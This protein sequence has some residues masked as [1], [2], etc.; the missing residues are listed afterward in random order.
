MSWKCAGLKPTPAHTGRLEVLNM[1]RF[2]LCTLPRKHEAHAGQRAPH[3]NSGLDRLER[4]DA[5]WCLDGCA[6]AL[7]HVFPG[8]ALV[9][10]IRGAGTGGAGASRAV[11]VAL[12]C[13]AVAFVHG[14]LRRLRRG[15]CR[16]SDHGEGGGEGAGDRGVGEGVLGIHSSF[17]S[18]ESRALRVDNMDKAFT[19]GRSKRRTTAGLMATPVL[20]L[21]TSPLLNYQLRPHNPVME[22]E[23]CNKHQIQLRYRLRRTLFAMADSRPI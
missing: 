6:S 1:G 4:A 8:I 9:V 20:L 7:R 13:D 15:E 21:R 10:G 11:V 12:H 5:L 22:T 17:L 23:F 14:G 3:C 2:R 16:G 18:L 19:V